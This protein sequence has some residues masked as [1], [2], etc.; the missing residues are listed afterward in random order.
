ME[1]LIVGADRLGNIPEVLAGY[2]IAIRKHISGRD[3]AHQKRCSLPSGINLVILFTD[4]LGHNVMK[5][6]RDA[7]RAQGLPVLCCRRSACSVTRALGQCGLCP[8]RH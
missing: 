3:P 4:F 1:A 5:R 6:F 2:G 7:A 8:K